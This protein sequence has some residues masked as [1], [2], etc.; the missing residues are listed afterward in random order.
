MFRYSIV[1]EKY[2]LFVSG[3]FFF[4]IKEELEEICKVYGIVKDI[5]LVINRVGKLKVS[6][7]VDSGKFLRFGRIFCICLEMV[8]FESAFLFVC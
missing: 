2:K 7:R 5:R 3:L 1:L 8:W 4:C 6:V